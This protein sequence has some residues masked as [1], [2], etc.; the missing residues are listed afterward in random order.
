MSEDW[1]RYLWAPSTQIGQ[2]RGRPTMV[3]SGQVCLVTTADGQRLSDA[4]AALW[5][6]N[7][8]QANPQLVE[9]VRQQTQEL[10]TY[11]IW[12]GSVHPRTVE[13]AVVRCRPI[14]SIPTPR[15]CSAPVGPTQASLPSSSPD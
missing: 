2:I 3:V 12:G 1:T 6:A 15:C 4:T 10:E 14:A 5:Y 8:G 9:A 7:L 11:Q 13:R